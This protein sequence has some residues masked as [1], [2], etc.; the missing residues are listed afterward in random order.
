MKKQLLSLLAFAGFAF[1]SQAQTATGGKILGSIKDG[2]IQ[3]IID[4][5][6][7]SLL[8]AQDSSLIKI[9]VTDKEG[10]FLFENLKDGDYL[11]LATSVGHAKTYSQ[12][13]TIN[14]SARNQQIGTLQLVQAGKNL[15]E[16]LVT[17]KK[18]FIERKAD[19]TIINV[20]AMIS[21]TGSTALDVL[22]KSPGV[23]VDKDGN[24]SLKGKQGVMIMIDG[25]PTYLSAPEVSNMLRNMSSN[26]L[27]QIEIMTNPSAKYDASGTAGLINIKTKKNKQKGFN[28]S[29]TEAYGQ[30]FY[31][32]NNNSVSLNY[33]N[34]KYNV[35]S[36]FGSN[37]RKSYNDLYILR[38]FKNANGSIK[39]I[40]EQNAYKTN[41]NKS[42][43]AKIGV[44]F[45]CNC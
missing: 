23:T 4:A 7:V 9:A 36:N 17:G 40:L 2:G 30:G 14:S 15:K 13:V 20:D 11:V 37:Y 5:A 21:N 34:G 1:A 25:K 18:Q 38:K 29:I 45:L 28:G 43:N 41:T 35:F 39:S 42:F 19:K 10:N 12:S 26:Q 44:D 22:E 32:K 6:S 8:K 27:D 16:V 24:I 31:S 3:K 33:K